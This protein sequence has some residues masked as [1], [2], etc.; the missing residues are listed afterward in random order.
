MLIS[1]CIP[2]MG[3]TDD[4]SQTLPHTI[5]ACR[6]SLPV[7]IVILNYDSKDNLDEYIRTVDYPITYVKSPNHEFFSISHSRNLAVIASRGD[8]AVVLDADISP[9]KNFVS[10]LRRIIEAESPDW[11]VEGGRFIHHEGR[12]CWYAGGKSLWRQGD[13]MRGSIFVGQRI[14]TFV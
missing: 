10:E 11:M 13:M 7:E 1:L 6:E 9:H 2:V 3:R 12:R 4:L 14:R 5:K 8:Y